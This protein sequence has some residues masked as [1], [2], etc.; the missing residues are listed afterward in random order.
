MA[1]P[2]YQSVML[3]LLSFTSD[4]QEHFLREII[5][6]LTEHYQL[7]EA[8]RHE[9]LPSGQQATFDNRVGWAATYMKK[10]EFLEST[11]KRSS[12]HYAARIRCS[13]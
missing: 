9:L 8:E 7:T 5:E 12:S 6:K 4:Q 11:R 1:I 3:P 10:A 2:D 13:P